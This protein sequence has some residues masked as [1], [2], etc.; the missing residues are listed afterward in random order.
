MINLQALFERPDDHLGAHRV[1][2]PAIA[3]ARMDVHLFT[4]KLRPVRETHSLEVLGLSEI[5]SRVDPES[6]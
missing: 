3:G 2:H 4:P 5:D 1:D 6:R